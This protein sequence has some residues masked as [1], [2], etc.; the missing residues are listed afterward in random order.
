MDRQRSGQVELSK[1]EE[2]AKVMAESFLLVGQ[3]VRAGSRQ[4]VEVKKQAR[5]GME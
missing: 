2:L 3:K 5:S 1:Y 4:S